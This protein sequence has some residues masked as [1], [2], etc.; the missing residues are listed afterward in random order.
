MKRNAE[1]SHRALPWKLRAGVII[2]FF[3]DVSERPIGGIIILL[4]CMYFTQ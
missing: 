4:F 1:I 3:V 2:A